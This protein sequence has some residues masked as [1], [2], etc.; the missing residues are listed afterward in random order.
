[1]PMYLKRGCNLILLIVLNSYNILRRPIKSSFGGNV[2]RPSTFLR[3]ASTDS[4]KSLHIKR[5]EE[6]RKCQI[7]I[8]TLVEVEEI[9]KVKDI[10]RYSSTIPI[11]GSF[12]K[13]T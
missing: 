5:I 4:G 11:F 10:Q 12:P 3:H 13:T 6:F 8:N 2:Q 9:G 1:M 7:L